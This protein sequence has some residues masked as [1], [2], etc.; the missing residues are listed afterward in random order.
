[1]MQWNW[2]RFSQEEQLG[3]EEI[4]GVTGQTPA[5]T[6]A[7]PESTPEA[8]R[9]DVSMPEN[10][11]DSGEGKAIPRQTEAAGDSEGRRREW[12]KAALE[13]GAGKIYNGW[14]REAEEVA[15]CYPG[16]DLRREMNNERFCALLRS[17]VDM[18]TAYEVLHS[19]EILPAAMEFAAKAARESI[20][21]ALQSSL[22]RPAEN[23]MG[24]MSAATVSGDP[25][26]LSRQAYREVC[27]RVERGERVTFG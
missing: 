1:M 15:R 23:G 7:E 12:N 5:E 22:R 3:A 20:S 18:K 2:Q 27:R 13:A 17:R 26:R 11:T 19:G 24:A 9:K 16:F 21:A 10:A 25:S 14:L 4:P 6:A 8:P